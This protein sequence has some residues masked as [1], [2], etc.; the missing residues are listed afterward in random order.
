M[1]LHVCV[2]VCVCVL[3]SYTQW[4][5]NELGLEPAEWSALVHACPGDRTPKEPL[6]FVFYN[7]NQ[8]TGE[9]EALRSELEDDGMFP[10]VTW[11]WQ[12]L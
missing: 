11:V 12:W 7:Y 10:H 6:E 1:V 3:R 9:Y 5:T 8:R 2:C 4:V